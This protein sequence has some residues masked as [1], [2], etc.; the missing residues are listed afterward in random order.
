MGGFT[1]WLRRRRGVAVRA[2]TFSLAAAAIGGAVVAGDALRHSSRQVATVVPEQAAAPQDQNRLAARQDV[3]AQP[4]GRRPE[5]DTFP[6]DPRGGTG[7]PDVQNGWRDHEFTFVQVV[8]GRSFRAGT[9]T[10][11]LTGIELPHA[12]QVCRTLDNRLEQ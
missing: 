8:D 7:S 4:E 5:N 1:A 3:A 2:A 11:R 9:M 12:D 10:I 6:G